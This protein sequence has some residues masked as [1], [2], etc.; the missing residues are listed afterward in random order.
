MK[1]TEEM[2]LLRFRY[3]RAAEMFIAYKTFL[4]RQVITGDKSYCPNEEVVIQVTHTL[5]LTFYSFIYSMFDKSGTDFIST[6]EPYVNVLTDAG[7]EVRKE[8]IEVW[9]K[10]EKAISKLRHNIGFHGGVK[11]KSHEV[12]YSALSDIHP[13]VVEFI[14]NHLAIF[15]MEMDVI[16]PPREDYNFHVSPEQKKFFFDRAEKFKK[17]INDPAFSRMMESMKKLYSDKNLMDDNS[18]R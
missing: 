2:Y 16:L 7:K 17:Q 13:Q 11:I 15:F 10:N 8:L 4:H 18:H 14:M 3:G 1:E 6:T 12:G 5:L 9:T